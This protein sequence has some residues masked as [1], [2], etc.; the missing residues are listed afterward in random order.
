MNS[1]QVRKSRV[2]IA[3]ATAA[4]V[5]GWAAFLWIAFWP[6]VYQVVSGTPVN[7][8]GTG[9]TETMV[10]RSSASFTDVNGYWT[11]IPLFVPLL[12]TGLALLFLLT[13]MERRAANA[14][15]VWGLSAVLLVFCG[16]GY[17]SVGILYLPA[18]IA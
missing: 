8:D 5:L 1:H 13:R 7:V 16:F 12:V 3:S 10:V 11:L 4:H 2:A 18:A 14:L 6:H 9:A 17:L 15:V